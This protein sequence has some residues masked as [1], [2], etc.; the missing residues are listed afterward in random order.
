[1]STLIP[2]V[3]ARIRGDRDPGAAVVGCRGIE[4]QP[5]TLTGARGIVLRGELDL[6]GAPRVEEQ[7][8]SALLDGTGAF[9]LD[10]SGLT[11]MD[12]TGVN[13]LLRARSL[14]GREQRDLVV[15][16][17]PGPVR[18]V[19]E[20]IGVVDVLAPF[21]SREDAAAALVAPD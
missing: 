15:I 17:P 1:M 6:L 2:A 12:S 7:V 11:F 10:L 5:I 14:L 9:V 4:A 13:T 18:R 20:L 8:Q 19:L 21:A 16:C 3:Y